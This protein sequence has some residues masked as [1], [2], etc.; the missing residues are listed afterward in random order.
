MSQ[1]YF[2]WFEIKVDV[3]NVFLSQHLQ[4]IFKNILFKINGLNFVL[5]VSLVNQPFHFLNMFG[6]EFPHIILAW[7]LQ[8]VSRN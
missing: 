1:Y 3:F 7:N 8:L 4:T 6:H 5:I 2:V